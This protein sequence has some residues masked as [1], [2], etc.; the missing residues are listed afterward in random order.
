MSKRT[1]KLT[2]VI[3]STETVTVTVDVDE[4]AKFKRN[5]KA[6]L[7]QRDEPAIPTY[8][9]NCKSP[10]DY[11]AAC[12]CWGITATTETAPTPTKTETVTVTE[13][14]CEDL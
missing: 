9:K 6:P 11:A 13:D 8:V 2:R 10:E 1:S 4:P 5:V 3:Y 7:E 12:S 14:Y